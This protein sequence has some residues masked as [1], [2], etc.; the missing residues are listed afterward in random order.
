VDRM[1]G[2][3]SVS[4]ITLPM[5][6]SVD[7]VEPSDAALQALLAT[8]AEHNRQKVQQLS[9]CQLPSINVHVRGFIVLAGALGS[10]SIETT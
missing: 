1:I 6:E 2:P 10:L 8:M 4:T 9:N 5:V 3:L 7:A